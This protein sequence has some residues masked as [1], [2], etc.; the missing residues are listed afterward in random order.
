MLAPRGALQ[1]A[2]K[3]PCSLDTLRRGLLPGSSADK[4]WAYGQGKVN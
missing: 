1:G 2:G 4:N 3:E